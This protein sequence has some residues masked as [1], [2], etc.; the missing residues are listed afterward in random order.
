MGKYPLDT[1][2]RKRTLPAP[3]VPPHIYPI[4][5]LITALPPS[6]A[7]TLLTYVF[8]SM[9][10]FMVLSPYC[11]SLDTLSFTHFLDIFYATFK[12]PLPSIYFP[13][14]LSVENS[15][16]LICSFL[17]SGFCPWCMPT[18][19]SAWFLNANNFP[20]KKTTGTQAM[21]LRRAQTTI[22]AFSGV[23]G[24]RELSNR[25]NEAGR[26]KT[27]SGGSSLWN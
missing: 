7:A 13:Y 23:C 8:V 4:P 11:V 10:L 21:F 9:C 12:W 3:R 5:I 19:P 17:L 18:H 22:I 6:K 2:R 27:W 14:H 1:R 24:E 16:H 26:K 25:G 20:L 15:G